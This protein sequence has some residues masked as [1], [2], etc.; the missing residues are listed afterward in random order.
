ML[1]CLSQEMKSLLNVS[2]SKKMGDPTRQRKKSP[3]SAGVEPTTSGFDRPLLYRLRYDA[4]RGQVDGGYHGNCGN[5]NVNGTNEYCAA[6]TKETNDTKTLHKIGRKK[7]YSRR[8][9][10][11]QFASLSLQR[12][13]H[14]CHPPDKLMFNQR[15][16]ERGYVMY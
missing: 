10:L 4:R 5:V 6:S 16:D 9:E 11:V 1:K 15:D 2:P 14:I 13:L 8:G 3:T 7:G 12:L